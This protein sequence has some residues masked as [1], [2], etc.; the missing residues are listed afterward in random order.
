MQRTW[1]VLF[2]VACVGC[3]DDSSSDAA[4]GSIDAPPGTPIDAAPGVGEPPE[5]E[6]ITLYHNQIRAEVETATPLPALEW[7]ADLA[8]TAAAWVAGCQN[9]DGF[10]S[11]MDHNDDRSQGHPYYV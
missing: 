10:P 8:A 4:D 5:L 11:I 6:G 7:D 1:A 9:T 2:V 3:G